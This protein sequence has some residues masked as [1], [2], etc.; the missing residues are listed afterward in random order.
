MKADV[1]AE[2]I[3]AEAQQNLALRFILCSRQLLW[4][5]QTASQNHEHL[6]KHMVMLQAGNCGTAVPSF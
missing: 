2:K 6:E 3:K 5:A 1:D 4:K